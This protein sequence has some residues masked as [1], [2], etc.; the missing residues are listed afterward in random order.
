M[1]GQSSLLSLNRLHLV[2]FI[3]LNHHYIAFIDF[4]G[5]LLLDLFIIRLWLRHWLIFGGS[6]FFNL[7]L[8]LNLNLRTADRKLPHDLIKLLQ[9]LIDLVILNNDDRLLLCLSDRICNW[10]GFNDRFRF[11][12][13][14]FWSFFDN[15]LFHWCW[16]GSLGLGWSGLWLLGW[17]CLLWSCFL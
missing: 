7:R 9:L 13:C 11:S 17:G 10:F 1:A 5:L 6:G 3:I 8:W 4:G 2:S 16:S 15:C 12:S 14:N